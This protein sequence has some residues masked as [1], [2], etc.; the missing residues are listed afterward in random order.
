MTTLIFDMQTAFMSGVTDKAPQVM[1]NLG[2]EWAEA[3]PQPI[4][5]EWKFV[6]CTNIPDVLPS[7]VRIKDQP[8]QQQEPL[9]HCPHRRTVG[10]WS[11]ENEF[12]Y[13]CKTFINH[14]ELAEQPAQQQEIK[15]AEAVGYSI[16]FGEGHQAGRDATPPAQRTWQGLTESEKSAAL[17]DK[18]GMTLDYEDY[19]EAI[20]A[21]LRS[22][23]EDRN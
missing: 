5:A 22:K 1:E 15:A 20:E 10:D 6:G 16:G 14:T 7:Y 9:Q 21:K 18:D 11:P 2:I 17:Y 4:F 12:C 3:H 23:N 13:D 8:A 19:A